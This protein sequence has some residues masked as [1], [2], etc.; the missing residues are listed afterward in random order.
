MREVGVKG[1][2]R[3]GGLNEGFVLQCKRVGWWGE[4]SGG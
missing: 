4:E 2:W 3:V 1:V